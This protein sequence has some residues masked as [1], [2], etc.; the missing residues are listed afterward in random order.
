MGYSFTYPLF[1]FLGQC[2]IACY[3]H[4]PTISTDMLGRVSQRTSAFNNNSTIAH[5][6]VLS[7]FKLQYYKLFAAIY[8]MTGRCADSVMVN[9]SWTEDHINQIWNISERTFKIY[10]PCDVQ[11]FLQI[12]VDSEPETF[13]IVAVAQFRPEK[14][15]PLMIR[16]FHTLLENISDEE[17]EKVKLVLVGSCRHS[18]DFKRVDD[19]KRLCKH[20]N[21]EDHV[22]F[23]LNVEF[24]QLKNLLQKSTI[25]LH[26]MWNEH[27]G[28]SINKVYNQ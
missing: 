7:W 3:V 5:S 17:R 26:A 22:E 18:E 13:R 4:Y 23:H 12:A 20:F 24:E 1:R 27:F 28:I 25:G 6:S 10:P 2:K 11:E 9:S 19:Y 14:D 21:M 16:S 8:A 15:H